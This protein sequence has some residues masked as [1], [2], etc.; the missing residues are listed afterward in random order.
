MFGV[1]ASDSHADNRPDKW[2]NSNDTENM[3]DILMNFKLLFYFPLINS[4]QMPRTPFQLIRRAQHAHESRLTRFWI[5]NEMRLFITI[6]FS[7]A[8]LPPPSP[9]F[10]IFVFVVSGHS[11]VCFAIVSVGR[12]SSTERINFRS[13]VLSIHC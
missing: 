1:L 2:T 10:C 7:I 13:Q 5:L 8:S 12:W 4:I 3:I 6:L 9:R 11:I